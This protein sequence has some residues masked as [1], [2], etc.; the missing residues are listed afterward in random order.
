MLMPR[1]AAALEHLR[2]LAMARLDEGYQPRDVAAF[3]EVSVRSVQRWAQVRDL[4]GEEALLMRPRP[5]RPPKL[6]AAQAAQVVSWLEEN[7]CDFGFPTQRWT[8]RRVAELIAKELG[9]QMHH[10]Y[11]SRWLRRRGITPQIPVRVAQ[12]R[13]EAEVRWWVRTVWPRIKKKPVIAMERLFSP[14]KPAF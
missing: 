1:K 2:R 6:D 5:G 7:P 14:M 9:V 3:L 11:L 4:H 12:E 8:A 13:D 10:R